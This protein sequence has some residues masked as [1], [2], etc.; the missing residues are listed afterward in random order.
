ME[1]K[2]IS[3]FEKM[4][5]E[6]LEIDA[7]MR[8]VGIADPQGNLVYSKMKSGKTRLVNHKLETMFASNLSLM[9]DMQEIFDES[10]GKTTLIHSIREKLHQLIYHVDNQMIYVTCEPNIDGNYLLELEKKIKSIIHSHIG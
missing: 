9:K 5:D 7:V 3:A 10:L 6:I 2:E 8:F 4:S 1:E